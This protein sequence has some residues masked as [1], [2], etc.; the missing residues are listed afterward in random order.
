MTERDKL[1]EQAFQDTKGLPA[2]GNRWDVIDGL[3]NAGWVPPEVLRQKQAEAW[4]LGWA[5]A[6]KVARTMTCHTWPGGIWRAWTV[7]FRVWARCP[8]SRGFSSAPIAGRRLT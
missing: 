8:A 2:K 3:V 1:I 7:L 5:A 4:D 6:R